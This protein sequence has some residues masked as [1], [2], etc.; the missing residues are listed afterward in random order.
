MK[1]YT[2]LIA[3]QHCPSQ[4]ILK[5]YLDIAL[6]SSS[7]DMATAIFLEHPVVAFIQQKNNLKLE[8]VFNMINDFSIDTYTDKAVSPSGYR[9]TWQ[10]QPLSQLK[11]QSRHHFIF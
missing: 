6:V 5:E 3:I 10:I 8:Q 9:S 11:A 2:H 1:R 4:L 7:Y